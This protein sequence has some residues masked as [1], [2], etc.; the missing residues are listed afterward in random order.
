MAISPMMKHYLSVKEQ[1]PDC[2]LFYR[3]G[4][5]Y[6]MFFDDAVLC[7]REL[8]LT[9]TKRN[10]G[11]GECAPMCGVPYHAYEV[12]LKR[13]I[14]KGYR[15]AICE[16]ISPVNPKGL[17]E[18]AIVRIVT[19]GT[20]IEDSILDSKEN[21]YIASVVYQKNSAGL[22][23]ADISTGELKLNIISGERVFEKLDDELAKIAPKEVITNSNMAEKQHELLCVI[24][25]IA[26][27]FYPYSENAFELNTAKSTCKQHFNVNSLNA[28]GFSDNELGIKAVGSLLKY[29]EQTQKTKASSLKK[30]EF[31]YDK[32]YVHLDFNS[33][34]NLEITENNNTHSKKGSLLWI[35]DKTKTSIG[36]RTIK[37]YVSEPL[38]N[39]M[40]INQRLDAVEELYTNPMLISSIQELLIELSDIERI[41]TRISYGT[42]TPFDLLA[43]KHTL[44]QMPKL[45]QLMDSCQ[46][47][48]LRDS[49][50]SIGDIKSVSDLIEKAIKPDLDRLKDNIKNGD[51]IRAGYNKELDELKDAKKL[52]QQWLLHYEQ[53]QKEKTG[54][55]NLR[56]GYNRVFGYFLEVPKSQI[57]KVPYEFVDRKQTT[58]NSERYVTETLKEMEKKILGSEEQA[59]KLEFKIYEDLKTDLLAFVGPIISISKSIGIIDALTSYA[60][61][62]NKNNYVK[63]YIT[64]DVKEIYIKNGR[65]PVVESIMPPGDFV[66][67]DTLLDDNENRTI[68][69]TGPNMGGKSTYLRQV[70][71]IT[72]MTHMG[73][74]VPASEARISPVD[75]LFT[76]IGA[77][78]DLI[79]GQSTF[80]VEMTEVAN[81][82][83]NA[84]SKSLLIM[85]EVGRGTSTYDGLSIARAVMEDISE[86]I[87]AKTLFATHYHELTSLE[88]TTIGVKNYRVLV[89]ETG[90]RPRFLHKIVRGSANKSFG[91]EVA[92]MAGI[93]SHV[94]NRAK[95]VLKIE[96]ARGEFFEKT[97]SSSPQNSHEPSIKATEI[98][99]ILKDTDMNNITPLVAFATLQNLIDKAKK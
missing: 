39:V 42:V 78:D 55:K 46:S 66:P 50:D 19:P 92:K 97:P 34:R 51:F 91:I 94:V 59:Q 36:A 93:P 18:R 3:L 40:L 71:A 84:T 62:A 32:N 70:A 8:D 45:R 54:I 74:F 85:D 16:Q 99:N 29:L 77:S 57:S 48:L 60:Y 95:D 53:E 43:L 83:N 82:L 38:A 67:N 21:N 22:A 14:D 56:I 89:S 41:A 7:S 52:G 9:L 75:K 31:V 65:H 20:I 87:K 47:N 1:N 72:L 96:E 5:F 80:M 35:L 2:I 12:Y 24:S 10:C 88:E 6:E 17:V 27:N 68:I 26:P 63:P 30:I 4:D 28:I 58:A 90:D 33:R 13:L 98:I 64:N 61:V 23:Y 86:R 79:F 37:Q 25:G 11:D 69:I 15:V 81:I 49:K 76:R 44:R 73:S